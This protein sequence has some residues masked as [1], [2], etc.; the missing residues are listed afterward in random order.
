MAGMVDR[1][2]GLVDGY[3]NE[4]VRIYCSQDFVYISFG[5]SIETHCYDTNNNYF[6]QLAQH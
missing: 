4:C 5:N 3:V 1:L 6:D 2:N